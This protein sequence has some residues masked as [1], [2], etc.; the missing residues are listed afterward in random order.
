MNEEKYIKARELIKRTAFN[1][2]SAM[3]HPLT[4]W[5]PDRYSDEPLREQRDNEIETILWQMNRE[6]SDLKR[7]KKKYD[8]D[9]VK[10]KS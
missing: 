5:R 3:F 7:K 10:A 9:R 4:K 2:I 1:K 6:I 8:E